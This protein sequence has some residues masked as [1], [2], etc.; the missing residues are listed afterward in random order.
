MPSSTTTSINYDDDMEPAAAANDTLPSV[1]EIEA[2]LAKKKADA[3]AAKLAAQK[4]EED[5]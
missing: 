1:A 3:A 4:E 2:R 5:L